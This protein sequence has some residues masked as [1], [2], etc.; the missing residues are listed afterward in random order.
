MTC[1]T[2]TSFSIH[3]NEDLHGYFKEK[4]GLRQGDPM[5]PYL[6]TLVM[7][8]RT[9]I[10]KRKVREECDFAYHNR[11]SKLKIINICFADD[12]IMFSRGDVTSPRLT[13]SPNVE[14]S[15]F[16]LLRTT[17]DIEDMTFDVYAL[18]CYGLVLFVTALFI[19][20]L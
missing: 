12:L 18:P 15:F 14:V 8:V 17:D 7:E 9:L 19:H 11:C 13:I 3:I 6:F 10:K 4:R 5:S 2:R 16:K 20:S 1:V